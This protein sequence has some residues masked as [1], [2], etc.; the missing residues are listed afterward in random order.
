M[1][2]IRGAGGPVPKRQ[3]RHR[4]K[5]AVPTTKVPA[6]PGVVAAPVPDESWH[7]TARMWFGSLAESGQAALYQPSD[8]AV[9][10]VVAESMSRE[11]SPQPVVSGGQV[12]M[13]A[14]PPK[15][16]A[17]SAWLKACTVL[18]ATEG[19]RRR[20]RLDLDDTT[21]PPMS[22]IG[23]FE[24]YRR[25]LAAQPGPPVPGPPPDRPPA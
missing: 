17:L 20:M 6:A 9:A 23:D 12:V 25:R 24:E 3:V 4:G 5:P 2:G 11:F 14:M 8:W 22:P 7:P 1:P 16:A 19:D 18:M 10:W 21:P 15:A 13:V